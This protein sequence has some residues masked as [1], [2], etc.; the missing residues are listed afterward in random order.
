M[1]QHKDLMG[2]DLHENKGVATA[3]DNFVAT[4]LSGATVW[5]KVTT[6]N[7]DTASIPSINVRSIHTKFVNAGLT[8]KTY[9]T[10]PFKGTLTKVDTVL[11]SALAGADAVLTVRNNA[12]SSAGTITVALSGSAAGD[13]DSLVPASNNTFVVGDNL[14]IESDGG[15]SNSPVIA[16]CYTFTVTS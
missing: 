12:G 7:I 16:V 6:S 3:S 8:E 13:K 14:S 1:P 5:Q 4:A 11:E 10:V 2:T 15:P 9:V